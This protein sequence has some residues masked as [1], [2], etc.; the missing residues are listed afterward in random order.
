MAVMNQVGL[1][2][3]VSVIGSMLIDDQTVA[4]V[5]AQ[6]TE[7]DFEGTH[8]TVYRA[9]RA[10]FLEGQAV[11]PVAVLHRLG[12]G[13]GYRQYLAG[14]MDST[15][16]AANV[17]NYV[18]ICREQARVRRARELGQAL[19]TETDPAQ[20]CRLL[21]EAAGLTAQ[22]QKARA[23]TMVEA[24][25]DFMARKSKKASYL[26]WPIRELDEGLYVEPG[27]FVVVGGRPSTGKTA[28]TI[29]CAYH[30]AKTYKVGYF[31]LETSPAKITDRLYAHIAGLDMSD[32]KQGRIGDA[33]WSAFAE[34]SVDATR[35][36]LEIVPAAGF[37]VADVR[38]HTLMRGYQIIVVDYLQLLQAAGDSRVAQVTSIS[39]GLHTLAQSLGVTVVALSQMARQGKGE[40][41]QGMDGLRESGQIEQDADVVMLLALEDPKSPKRG[42]PRILRIEKNKEGTCDG[43]TLAFDGP[44]QTFSKA[45]DGSNTLAKMVRDGKKAHREAYRPQ[46]G[47]ITELSGET[48][49]P[50]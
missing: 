6:T 43:I 38:A 31:S 27:D 45:R 42:Q 29:Q 28:W 35:R 48:W 41:V 30:W 18:D 8:R 13:D 37:S 47:Q 17:S 33:G 39:I 14:C 22:Q 44:H 3:Q 49:V 19:V 12:N 40:S 21:E 36:T 46:Q 16:T 2:A 7:D 15:P 23:V 1:D 11:D 24:A 9:I 50:F 10:L 25:H 34:A 20:V 5:M 26:S 32:I 4:Q